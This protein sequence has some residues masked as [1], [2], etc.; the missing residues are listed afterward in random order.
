MII[1][2][3]GSAE[4]YDFSKKIYKEKFNSIYENYEGTLTKP[5]YKTI[6]DKELVEMGKN[7]GFDLVNSIPYNFFS[8]NIL[9]TS[10]NNPNYPF[11][12]KFKEYFQSDLFAEFIEKFEGEVINN[13]NPALTFYKMIILK[14][15]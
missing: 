7:M 9:M 4:H 10:S 5:F 12:E 6:F 8:S 3:I 1:F 11:D 14:K 13:S 15:N 2:N